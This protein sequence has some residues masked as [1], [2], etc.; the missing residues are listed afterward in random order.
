MSA[1]VPVV[2]SGKNVI[3]AAPTVVEAQA[4]A[5][6]LRAVFGERVVTATS[7]DPPAARTDAWTQIASETGSVVVGTREVAFWGA[8]TVG[9]AVVL[10]EGRRGLQVP[11]DAHLQRA[12][13]PPSAIGHRT[14]RTAPDRC[15]P[16]IRSVLSRNRDRSIEAPHLAARGDRRSKRGSRIHGEGRRA[17]QAGHRGRRRNR[18]GVCPR[19]TAWGHVS[20]CGDVANSGSVHTCDA[21][22]ERS[23]VVR[24]VRT[25]IP[26]CIACGGT[27]F[28]ALGSGVQRIVDDLTRTFGSDV[29]SAGIGPQ[30]HRGDRTRPRRSCSG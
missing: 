16:N 13:R 20:M 23:G 2:R 22:L 5:E 7:D 25:D 14:V 12:R 3:V 8:G 15:R 9:L 24:P 11:S 4:A 30:D 1:M 21:L 27:R 6:Q 19:A 29:G 26:S 18:N 10:E 17:G 28:E